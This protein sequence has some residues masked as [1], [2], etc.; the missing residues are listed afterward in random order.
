MVF[1]SGKCIFAT[2]RT[3]FRHLTNTA[4][5]TTNILKNLRTLPLTER[6]PVL[7][8]GGG[9]RR[10]A[11]EQNEAVGGRGKEAAGIPHP[12]AILVVSARWLARST[13]IT[14]MEN[15]PTSHD[16]G[17]FP[18]ELYEVNYAAPG[19]PELASQ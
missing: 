4:A 2:A 14:A 11:V 16:L 19:S 13:N 6:M 8:L 15:P 9:S 12:K 5:M 10:A 1:E 18:K 17:G 7:F 3:Y